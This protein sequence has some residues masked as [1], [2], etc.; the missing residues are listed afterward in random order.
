MKTILVIKNAI[1]TE[2]YKFVNGLPKTYKYKYDLVLYKQDN[3][4]IVGL[5]KNNKLIHGGWP[6]EGLFRAYN[7]NQKQVGIVSNSWVWTNFRNAMETLSKK[8]GS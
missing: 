1:H 8:L 4:I 5:S 7:I 6:Y 3:H 2:S